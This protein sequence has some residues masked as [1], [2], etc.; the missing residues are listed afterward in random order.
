M[1]KASWY[2][3]SLD[4]ISRYKEEFE[5]RNFLV[6]GNGPSLNKLPEYDLS[7]FCIVACNNAWRVSSKWNKNPDFIFITD[8]NRA[9]EIV[10]ETELLSGQIVIGDHDA[11]TPSVER[12]RALVDSGA[13]CIRQKLIPYFQNKSLVVS[14]ISS[15][16]R[17]F[18]RI[19]DK[20]YPSF[21][22]ELGYNFGY[23]VIIPAIQ[24]SVTMG[25]KRIILM[26]VDASSSAG[27]YFEGMPES[28][29]R[30]EEF[31]KN[32][33]LTIEPGL[34]MLR[35]ALDPLGV[36]LLDAS[37]GALTSLKS[38]ELRRL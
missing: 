6:L 10:R 28:L 3:H 9:Q 4:K 13:L 7:D 24:F 1:K 21:D 15:N 36:D 35:A 22:P 23:S 17:L 14:I 12:Y 16:N 31:L 20:K 33:R 27:A 8:R 19:V 25:A 38:Y 5:G 32:P 11:V 18:S 34:A 37:A 2:G 26:G 30:D 29:R